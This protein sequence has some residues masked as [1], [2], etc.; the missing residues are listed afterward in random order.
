MIKMCI[1]NGGDD[2]NPVRFAILNLGF[3]NRTGLLYLNVAV[4]PTNYNNSAHQWAF[5]KLNGRYPFYA[6]V[7]IT[8]THQ[9]NRKIL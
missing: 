9:K 4:Y 2:D 8:E 7:S 3:T 5:V 6:R 1:I